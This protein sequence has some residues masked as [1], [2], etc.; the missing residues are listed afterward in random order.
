MV[1][2]NT[3]V[4]SLL[5]I[6]NDS[7]KLTDPIPNRVG[8]FFFGMNQELTMRYEAPKGKVSAGMSN[9]EEWSFGRAKQRD[10]LYNIHVGFFTPQ[11]VVD[12][13]TGRKN[14]ELV[15]Q[16]MDLIE[17]VTI[18]YEHTL[19]NVQLYRVRIE[20][21]PFFIP[22]SNVHGARLLFVFRERK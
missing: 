9:S 15:H 8:S 4:D 2:T 5:A 6:Y 7:T 14:E 10:K 20:E 3:L 22:E 21:E 19:G 18:N 13:N 16:Y 11:G 12:Q 1:D 17:Q